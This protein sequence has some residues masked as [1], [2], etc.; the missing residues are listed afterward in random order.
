MQYFGTAAGVLLLVLATAAAEAGDDKGGI[1]APLE[2][3]QKVV[4]KEVGDRYQIS[5][6]PGLG[7][8][9]KIVEV[10]SDYIVL[11]DPAGVNEVRIP[12]YSV[13]SV[14]VTRLPRK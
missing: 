9:H 8:G 13:K 4:L 3:G 12:I 7:T 2:E 14:T 1:F 11:L 10:G 5:V 6:V